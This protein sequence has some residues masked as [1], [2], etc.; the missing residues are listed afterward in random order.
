MIAARI[1]GMNLEDSAHFASA[2]SALVAAGLGSDAGIVSFEHTLDRM[3]T[4]PRRN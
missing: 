3:R 4:L 2:A 1:R